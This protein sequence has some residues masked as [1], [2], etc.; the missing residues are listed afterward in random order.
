[1]FSLYKNLNYRM[2]LPNIRNFV[3]IPISLSAVSLDPSY[4]PV[5]PSK[6]RG[7]AAEPVAI[8]SEAAQPLNPLSL[9][10]PSTEGMHNE[11]EECWTSMIKGL[12]ISI[13]KELEGPR[14]ENRI[15]C[16]RFV[17]EHGYPGPVLCMG[18]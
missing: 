4:K 1:M 8:D 14:R 10:T 12:E 6:P 3:R 5:M 2:V 16:L 11:I 13:E 15:A 9:P 17:R 18:C 7:A